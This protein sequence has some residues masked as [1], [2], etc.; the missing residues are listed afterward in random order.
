MTLVWYL[1]AQKERYVLPNYHISRLR[2]WLILKTVGY[3]LSIQAVLKTFYK[4]QSL[5]PRFTVHHFWPFLTFLTKVDGRSLKG[6][7]YVKTVRK[8][9]HR[10]Y[11]GSHPK[12]FS[13]YNATLIKTLTDNFL[14]VHTTILIKIANIPFFIDPAS[15][16]TAAIKQRINAKMVPRISDLL[17]AHSS[18]TFIRAI[19]SSFLQK[20]LLTTLNM[21][22]F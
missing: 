21:V 6:K 7:K 5:N 16:S 17:V 12:H 2:S 18:Q 1:L 19:S 15:F 3:I 9:T 4:F 11:L 13:D 8:I 14:I 10:K 22:S 20:D